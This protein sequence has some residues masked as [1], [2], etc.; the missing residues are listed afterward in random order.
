MVSD[1]KII[2][3]ILLLLIAIPFAGL[4]TY[5]L[6]IEIELN[7]NTAVTIVAVTVTLLFGILDIVWRSTES[8]SSD[9]KSAQDLINDI[10]GP[11]TTVVE[12][13]DTEEFA[14]KIQNAAN[15]AV[16]SVDR[17]HFNM[18]YVNRLE[19]NFADPTVNHRILL[20]KPVSADDPHASNRTGE[21]SGLDSVYN[22]NIDT[23]PPMDQFIQRFDYIQ[24]AQNEN[25]WDNVDVQL[26]ETTPWLR[27]AIIDS[28]KAGFLLLPSMY[29]GARAAKFWTE[30]PNVV[31]TLESIYDDIWHDPRTE[32]FQDWYEDGTK[33]E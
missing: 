27:A 20:A 22:S 21:L 9:Q 26:Y 8:G 17:V 25:R 7:I 30:D 3:A 31:D 12:I 1:R 19:D 6:Y 2:R 18:H 29:D 11:D 15:N 13:E 24:A 33:L 16:D 5:F 28:N 14:E 32:C 4:L 23:N 10:F